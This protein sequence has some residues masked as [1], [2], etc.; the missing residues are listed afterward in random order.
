MDTVF[1]EAEPT[2]DTLFQGDDLTDDDLLLTPPTVYGFGLLDRR[3]CKS[4][5]KTLSWFEGWLI[6]RL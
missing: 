6:C 5:L 1:N 4:H 2:A 3:W